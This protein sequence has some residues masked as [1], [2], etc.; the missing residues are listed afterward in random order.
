MSDKVA[1]TRVTWDCVIA[2]KKGGDVLAD[3]ELA[4]AVAELVAVVGHQVD[5]G[6]VGLGLDAAVA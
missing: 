6:Q 2:G 5:R 4:F 3:R 1:A